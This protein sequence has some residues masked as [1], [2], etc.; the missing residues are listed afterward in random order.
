MIKNNIAKYTEFLEEEMEILQH[1]VNICGLCKETG[2]VLQKIGTGCPCV[3]AE[4]FESVRQF[5][6]SQSA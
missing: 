1:V 2:R 5:F 3:T 4:N 6:I